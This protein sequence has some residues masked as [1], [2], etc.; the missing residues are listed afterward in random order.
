MPTEVNGNFDNNL[1]E[2]SVSVWETKSHLTDARVQ[3]LDLQNAILDAN[4]CKYI[5]R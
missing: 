4:G 2:V 5:K 3:N 1:S